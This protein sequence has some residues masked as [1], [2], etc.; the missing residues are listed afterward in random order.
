MSRAVACCLQ[1]VL[2]AATS[3]KELSAVPS[4]INVLLVVGLLQALQTA[5]RCLFVPPDV[6][7]WK[8]WEVYRRQKP[9]WERKL[10]EQHRGQEMKK[11][12][13]EVKRQK[14]RE[15][16]EGWKVPIN[17]RPLACCHLNLPHK[18]TRPDSI[19]AK[20]LYYT[21]TCRHYLMAF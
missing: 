5:A 8:L 20:R 9:G 16:Q 14:R 3:Q 7:K 21:R 18:H 6:L 19:I 10:R 15:E 11:G 17:S 13:K 1:E 12:R 4:L 2:K